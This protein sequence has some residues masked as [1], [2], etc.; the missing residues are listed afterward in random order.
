MSPPS[1][2]KVGDGLFRIGQIRIDTAKREVAVPGKANQVTTLEFVANTEGGMKAYESA[3]TLNTGGVAFNAALL[4]IGLDPSHA[5]VPTRH[6]DPTPPAGDPVEIWVEWNTGDVPALVGPLGLP[7]RGTPPTPPAPSQ[8]IRVRVEQLLFDRR[9]N[10][11]LPEGPWVYTGSSFAPSS[12]PS[13]PPRFMSDLDGVLIGFVHSPAPVIENPG[14]GAVDSFGFVVM[15]PSI[16]L[17]PETPVIV[18]VKA[19]GRSTTGRE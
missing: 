17:A 5:R 6:F 8:K 12:A 10:Q 18:T 11:T 13:D 15:N 4:L 16:G 2:Q 3:L 1:V 19:I 9:T 7:S 14:R